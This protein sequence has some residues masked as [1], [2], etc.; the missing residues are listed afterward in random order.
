MITIVVVIR[1][2]IPGLMSVSQFVCNNVATTSQYLNH[3][4]SSHSWVDF[5]HFKS[6]SFCFFFSPNAIQY[7]WFNECSTVCFSSL[8]PP[9][10]LFPSPPL[11]LCLLLSFCVA[12][13]CAVL[14]L[15]V[16]KAYC[17]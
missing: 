7:V 2:T 5:P 1:M 17:F 12:Y 6:D 9:P 3:L 13:Q 16:N 8:P 15:S 14:N 4:K 10:A 11:P